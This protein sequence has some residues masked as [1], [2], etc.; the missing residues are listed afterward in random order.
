MARDWSLRPD[1]NAFLVY[2]AR[3][4]WTAAAFAEF[5]PAHHDEFVGYARHG[6]A[7]LDDSMRDK[8]QGGFHWIVGC[9][10]QAR[11]SPGRRKTRLWHRL[12]RLRRECGAPGDRR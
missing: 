6:I 10:R 1:D 2:Q 7:F 9:R 4:T 12:C 3:M 5:S 8:E 11:P